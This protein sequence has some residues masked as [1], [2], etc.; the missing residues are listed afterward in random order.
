[1]QAVARKRRL[2]QSAAMIEAGD[3]GLVVSELGFRAD[4]RVTDLDN[5]EGLSVYEAAQ[6]PFS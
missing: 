5:L 3:G 1:M 4:G 6:Y 2:C